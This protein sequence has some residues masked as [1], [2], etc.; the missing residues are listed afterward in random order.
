[1]YISLCAFDGPAFKAS[2]KIFFSLFTAHIESSLSDDACSGRTLVLF[3]RS[4][5]LSC[6]LSFVRS[7]I[8]TAQTQIEE[9]KDREK[10]KKEVVILYKEK[11]CLKIN[12]EKNAV[13]FF[14]LYFFF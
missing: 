1:M 6:V 11:I 12:A 9:K 4:F 8:H 10:T 5:V 14:F 2:S 7:Y 3:F 13:C